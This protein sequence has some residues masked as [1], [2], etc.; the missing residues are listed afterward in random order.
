M[1][2][3]FWYGLWFRE[4]VR[5]KIHF[6]S[7]INS[8]LLKPSSS[9]TQHLD[10]PQRT[11]GLATCSDVDSCLQVALLLTATRTHKGF[12][13]SP[14]CVRKCCCSGGCRIVHRFLLILLQVWTPAWDLTLENFFYRLRYSSLHHSKPRLGFRH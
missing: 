5:K 6:C 7:L 12:R 2:R 1:V 3:Q 11:N 14:K 9:F 10:F 4:D 8:C 13:F